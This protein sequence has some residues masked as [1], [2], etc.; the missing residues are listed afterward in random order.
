MNTTVLR[1]STFL[2]I[3]LLSASSL[4]DVLVTK[5]GTRYEGEIQ[6]LG[7]NYLVVKPDGG[8]MTF[9]KSIVAR[10][11]KGPAQPASRGTSPTPGPTSKPASVPVGLGKPATMTV[12]V[13][14][15]GTKPEEALQNAFSHSI[16]QVNGM[17]VDAETLVRNEQL[18]TDRVL[19]YSRGLVKDYKVVRE[20][21]DKD[22]HYV[23]IRADVKL[24]EL[25]EKLKEAQVTTFAVRGDLLA[26]QA[27]HDIKNEKDAAEML[28]TL[29][30]DYGATKMMKVEVV[31]KPEVVEKT[32]TGVK[33][34]IKVQISSDPNAWKQFQSRLFELLKQVASDRGQCSLN[35]RSGGWVDSLKSHGLVCKAGDC[36]RFLDWSKN[37][38]SELI[39]RAPPSGV[40]LLILAS[41][42]HTGRDGD[43]LYAR[44]DWDGFLVPKEVQDVLEDL[45]K[46]R[47]L[48]QVELKDALGKTVVRVQWDFPDSVRD[49]YYGKGYHLLAPGIFYWWSDDM[50]LNLIERFAPEDILVDVEANRLADVVGGVGSI[51]ENPPKKK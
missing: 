15:S 51:Q 47:Y 50:E 42:T 9:P 10:V 44:L 27:W 28:K 5:S 30:T 16:E 23:C 18:I 12:V 43:T 1:W 4:A 3:V 17:M 24:Q 19:T 7:D 41:K 33:L 2:G 40:L 20:W 35:T 13:I 11:E 48:L 38:P 45:V 46:K 22:L 21:K 32:D 49:I 26:L 8:R 6:D 25:Q 34:R 29:L 31:G 37:R 39:K 14:G 36:W